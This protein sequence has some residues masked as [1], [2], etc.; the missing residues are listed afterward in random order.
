MQP[1]E[2]EYDLEPDL[3]LSDVKK[4]AC[5]LKNI[6]ICQK[7]LNGMWILEILK[8]GGTGLSWQEE[9]CVLKE[10]FSTMDAAETF[11]TETNEL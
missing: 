2:L 8:Q 11:T 10:N 7:R 1:D 5:G 6:Y 4:K 3:L 9:G